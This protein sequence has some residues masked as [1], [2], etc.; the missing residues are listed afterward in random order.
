MKPIS[1][2]LSFHQI[3]HIPSTRIPKPMS[4]SYT[5]SANRVRTLRPTTSYCCFGGGWDDSL[6]STDGSMEQLADVESIR[7]PLQQSQSLLER[8]RERKTSMGTPRLNGLH[9][10]HTPR[11]LTEPLRSSM[12]FLRM[13]ASMERSLMLSSWSSQPPISEPT[14]EDKRL[15]LNGV[16]G[17]Y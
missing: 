11:A 14:M 16:Y 5:E 12:N 3:L 17:Q 1:P 8:I 9:R 15:R 13:G 6:T 2:R 7:S 10:T 4:R